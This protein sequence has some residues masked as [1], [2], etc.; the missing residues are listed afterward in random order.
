MD[1]KTFLARGHSPFH[2]V[3]ACIEELVKAGFKEINFH[4]AGRLEAGKYY[5]NFFGSSL[6]AFVLKGNIG[7]GLRL[8]AAHTDI[9]TVKIKPKGLWTN[10]GYDE[11]NGE[12]YGGMVLHSWLDRPLGMAGRLMIRGK[13]PF[14][15]EAVLTDS[16]RAVAMIPGLAIHMNRQVNEGFKLNRQK[17]FIPVMAEAG[18]DSSLEKM[19]AEA[20]GVDEKSILSYDLNLYPVEECSRW[21]YKNEFF[22]ATGLDNLVSCKAALEG[23]MQADT[24]E[25]I[26]GIAL[27]DNEEVGSKTKQGAASLG[28]RNVLQWLCLRAGATEEEFIPYLQN[29]SMLSLDAAHGLHPNYPE[30]ADPSHPVYL[31]RG[32]VIKKAANQAYATD[33]VAEAVVKSICEAEHIPYQV[34]VNHNNHPGGSTL[35]SVGSA[36]LPM[37]TADVGIPLWSMHSAR[38]TMGVKDEGALE[39]LARAWFQ[40]KA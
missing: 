29:G 23:L 2:V 18:E 4:D 38:E 34:F 17:E 32:I 20:A 26:T 13:N 22:T 37:L 5:I 25:G 14:R 9:P 11:L 39:N 6:F 40:L 12:V 10:K 19:L 3:A 36:L 35:G 27:F 1:L 8:I 31:N 16:K 33:G 28:L 15:P 21:G 30:Y 7:A 24:V